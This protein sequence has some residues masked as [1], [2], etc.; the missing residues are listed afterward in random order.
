MTPFNRTLPQLKKPSI[1]PSTLALLVGALVIIGVILMLRFSA[2]EEQRELLHWQNKLNLIA[3]SRTADIS[4]WLSRN[5]HEL[6]GVAS[7]PSLQ[8]YVTALENEK[9]PGEL[10]QEEP[11][12]AVF[13]RN[14]LLMT[15][16]R[17]GFLSKTPDALKAINANVHNASGTG[18][19]IVDNQGKILV[20]TEGLSTLSSVVAQKVAD[21]PRG[22]ST[23]ID[24]FVSP[25]GETQ[26]GFVIPIYPIQGEAVAEQQIGKLVGIKTAGDDFFKLLEHPGV[27]D[28]TLQAV[29]LRKEDSNVVYISPI[30][31]SKMLATRFALDTAGLDAAFAIASPG[32]FAVKHDRLS[33]TVLMTSRLITNAP[34]TLLLAVDRDQA[35]ME[36]D[37]WRI[38]TEFIMFVAIL[39]FVASIIAAWWYGTSRRAMLL[40]AQTAHLAAHS[41]AQEK[42]LRL[43]T[44]NQPSP[45]FIADKNNIVRFA[46]TKAAEDFH[47][48][49]TDAVGKDLPSL[50][51]SAAAKIY[52]DINRQ[53]LDTGKM[54]TDTHRT[55]GKKPAVI[56]SEHLPL[57]H[58]PIDSLPFPSPGV[59]VIKQDVTDIVTERERR[60]RTL[61]HLVDTLVRMVDERDPYSANHSANVAFLAREIGQDLSISLE[62]IE[63]AETAGKLMNIGKILVPSNIL[64][65]SSSL[66]KDEIKTIRDSLN[67]S[68]TVLEKIEF[69]GPVVDT[70]KQAPEHFDGSGPLQ[71]K[72]ENILITA[73]IIAVANS[74]IGM[75]SPRSYRSA[76]TIEQTATLLLQDND[77]QF[78]RRV[79]IALINF[80]E[81]RNGKKLLIE[82]Q[83]ANKL[84]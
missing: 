57:A 28:K 12:Q 22:Q 61:H 40:S 35:L 63:T 49:A 42:L 47:I 74:F 82:L 77:K 31:D 41:I 15:A 44:D 81:N 23:L 46:N 62:L 75:I 5:F 18:L 70:L 11:A 80:I 53:A 76:I 21:A 34:W 45:I 24:L 17:L 4:S 50:M 58:I 67:E 65:K 54:L 68:I 51:G 2:A 79:V 64:T 83:A 52:V 32:T 14:L 84:K 72:G 36:S 78:D 19:A 60:V 48:P 16:D 69:D 20:S 3:D 39:A 6:E 37:D 25:T 30:K 38:K 33:H 59:L 13:L 55:E 1:K 27:T 9:N 43:V 7:N 8:L 66:A 71:L 26:I 56:R 29:L 73:R 10:S